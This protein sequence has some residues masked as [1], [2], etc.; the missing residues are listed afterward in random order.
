MEFA[1]Y[2]SLLLLLLLLLYEKDHDTCN[3]VVD[4][5]DCKLEFSR[6]SMIN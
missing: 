2:K 6:V 4:F 3:L 5:S 1:L